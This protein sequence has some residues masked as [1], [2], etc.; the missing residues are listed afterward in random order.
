MPLTAKQERFCEE[1]IVDLNA[2]QAAIRAGYSDNCASEIGYENLS[3]PQ[4]AERIAEMKA[5]RSQR[6]KVD[7]DWVLT[8]A[9]ETFSEC[10]E[11]ERYSAGASYLRMVGSHVD[12]Q[13]FKEVV[14]HS[15]SSEL[16]DIFRQAA[17]GHTLPRASDG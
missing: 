4:I 6:T 12:V 11:K 10:R 7:A 1:Y 14:E 15:A 3:K 8:Q 5:E 16:E 2:T 9:S 17:S 13:A